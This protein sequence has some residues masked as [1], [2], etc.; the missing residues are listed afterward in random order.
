MPMPLPADAWSILK[1]TSRTFIIPITLLAPGL[2]EA[3][4]AAYLCLRAIDQIEDHATLGVQGKVDIL[5]RVSRTLQTAFHPDDFGGVF[6]TQAALLPTVT[7]R[8]GEWA[9]LAPAPVAPRIWDATAAMAERMAW[10][11]EQ[12]WRIETS[13][14]PRRLH[15]RRRRCGW[16]HAL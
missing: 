16:S 1:E 5:R 13:R 3:V 9:T 15:F 12:R 4:A 10:W 8:L 7:L 14:R 6:G 2:Q 11:A